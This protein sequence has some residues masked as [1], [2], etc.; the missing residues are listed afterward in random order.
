MHIHF[1]AKYKVQQ[2]FWKDNA[3]EVTEESLNEEKEEQENGIYKDVDLY[4]MHTYKD[5]I[6][7]TGGAYIL[8][9][10]DVNRKMKGFHEI[11]P[12]LGAFCI[13]PNSS[14][15]D[16][17]PLKGFIKEVVQHLFDRASQREKM[18]YYRHKTYVVK[19]ESMVLHEAL[20][21]PYGD[22]RDLLLDDTY[23]L[24]GYHKNQEHLEWILKSGLYNTKNRHSKWFLVVIQGIG[25]HKIFS[26]SS[27]RKVFSFH[28]VEG[29]S[30][31]YDG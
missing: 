15:V 28:K 13:K 7:R 25:K 8:Y 22:N 27:W 20:P 16:L 26:S 5:A 17:E 9:P 11:I 4:K 1:D 18:A 19:Q 3:N 2:I 6:R 10:G 30:T 21:E 12:G 14:E 29:C 31:Y 23:V 24:I